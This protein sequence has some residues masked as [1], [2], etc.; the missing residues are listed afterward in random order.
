M[1]STTL[2]VYGIGCYS[3]QCCDSLRLSPCMFVIIV[4]SLDRV[5]RVMMAHQSEDTCM[6]G[7]WKGD[8]YLRDYADFSKPI[9]LAHILRKNLDNSWST[10]SRSS[11]LSFMSSFRHKN[12]NGPLFSPI[13]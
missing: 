6:K 1:S 13:S 5:T 11:P 9:L 3:L 12:A 8:N 7:E 10:R 2:T 4:D